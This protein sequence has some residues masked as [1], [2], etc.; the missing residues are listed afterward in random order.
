MG[1]IKLPARAKVYV[2]GKKYTGEIPEE[3]CPA[4]YKKPE[5]KPVRPDNAES[6]GNG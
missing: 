6:S 2:H 4:K 1:M 5:K 3:I